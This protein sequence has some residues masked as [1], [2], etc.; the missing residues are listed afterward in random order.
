MI[1]DTFIRSV[2]EQDISVY[3]DKELKQLHVNLQNKII[4]INKE[5]S[6]P[7]TFRR[8]NNLAQP[9]CIYLLSLKAVAIQQQDRVLALLAY[10]EKNSDR[11]D[12]TRSP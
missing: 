3:T 2:S 8:E 12:E 5:I 10:R 11:I 4:E 9:Y 7:D 1:E 6:K